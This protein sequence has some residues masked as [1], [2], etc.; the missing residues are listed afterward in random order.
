[1]AGVRPGR[2]PGPHLARPAPPPRPRLP[3]VVLHP[4]R[5]RP[6]A[7]GFGRR[8]HSPLEAAAATCPPPAAGSAPSSPPA[9]RAR[10]A[11]RA[12]PAPRSPPYGAA[13]QFAVR[14]DAKVVLTP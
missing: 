2:L 13:P 8:G 14:E 1:Q 9:S 5:H 4:T 10:T 7:S 3:P 6:P 11:R 12:S